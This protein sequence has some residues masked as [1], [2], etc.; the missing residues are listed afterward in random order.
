MFGMTYMCT[1]ILQRS[2]CC[3]SGLNVPRG[4][5]SICNGVSA[6]HLTRSFLHMYNSLCSQTHSGW[7]RYELF[8]SLFIHALAKP[9]YSHELYPRYAPL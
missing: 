9:K 3:V 2:V 5:R 4:I 7:M 8:V 6:S 1:G